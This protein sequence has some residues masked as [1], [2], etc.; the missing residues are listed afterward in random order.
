MSSQRY[1]VSQRRMP[2]RVRLH[3]RW[4]NH[5]EGE[6][7][8]SRTLVFSADL[9]HPNNSSETSEALGTA[10]VCGKVFLHSIGG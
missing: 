10:R 9:S 7:R 4:V 8:R 2:P 6:I 5:A 1:G 3:R